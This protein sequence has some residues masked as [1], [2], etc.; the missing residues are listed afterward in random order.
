[1]SDLES[2]PPAWRKLFEKANVPSQQRLAEDAGVSSATVNRMVRSGRTT[3]SSVQAVADILTEGDTEPIWAA[4][5]RPER[6]HG[7]FPVDL[8]ADDLKLLTPK[9]RASLIALVRSMAY[10]Q[11]DEAGTEHGKRSAEKIVTEADRPPS[12]PRKTRTVDEQIAIDRQRR[13][14]RHKERERAKDRKRT[15]AKGADRADTETK[16]T[17]SAGLDA[18]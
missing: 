10:P 13:A 8:I 9:Q 2:L 17:S 6:D 1:M 7:D 15:Q 3:P 14:D 18:G 11:A 12:A 4:M 5:Q 16:G